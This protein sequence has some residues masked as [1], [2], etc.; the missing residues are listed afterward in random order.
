MRYEAHETLVAP[1]RASAAP[2]RLLAGAALTMLL[3]FLFTYAFSFVL[4]AFIAPDAW[5][6]F[7][8]T[9][10]TG[11]TPVSVLINLYLFLL[12][13]AALTIALRQIHGRDLLGLFGPLPLAFTQFRRV[14]LYLLGLHLAISVLV[15]S[16]PDVQ[17]Q[18]HMPPAIWL[19]F[20][21]LA[22]PA[23]LI[24]TGAEELV[25]RGYMQSQL[26]A[27]F[28]RPVVWLL[29][30]SVLF[31]LLHHDSLMHGDNAW[32]VVGWAVAFGIAAADLTAR[33]GTL[34]PA[35]ALHF[36]N[37]IMAILLAAPQGNF[38]GLAL[39][40]FP[41]GL[42]EASALWAW[43]PVDLMTLFCGWLVARLALR[44]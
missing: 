6:G 35:I 25:F 40:T 9:L 24:Q 18:L 26:A 19:A 42:D 10:E 11:T 13:I 36:M 27:R 37:N 22:I 15:P 7:A 34:G 21:P 14:C 16:P 20:L 4:G 1:A 2:M 29:V 33:A 38:D 44:R 5:E 39:F 12:I 41:F 17:A 23:V 28:A 8:E 3:F 32:L 43:A 30:P 31:G